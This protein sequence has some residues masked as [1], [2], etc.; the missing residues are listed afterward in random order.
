MLISKRT[1][2][3]TPPVCIPPI[4]IG[5]STVAGGGRGARRG[6]GTTAQAWATI[7]QSLFHLELYRI[8]SPRFRVRVRVNASC[9]S[10]LVWSVTL[11][12][13]DPHWYPA[14]PYS[15]EDRCDIIPRN[16]FRFR[17]TD[18]AVW[19]FSRRPGKLRILKTIWVFSQS[20]RPYN[21]VV[22]V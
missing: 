4:F 7:D 20:Y 8:V 12:S 14:L 16:C 3:P 9:W 6:S 2:P 22:W 11:R 17:R 5:N 19:S 13:S 18:L 15:A 21:T 10:S 1:H